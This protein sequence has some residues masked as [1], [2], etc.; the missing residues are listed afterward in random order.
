VADHQPEGGRGAGAALESRKG[1]QGWLPRHPARPQPGRSELPTA[2]TRG[3]APPTEHAVHSAVT[4]LGLPSVLRPPFS[5][6]RPPSL[7]PP[8]QSSCP[9]RFPV[10]CRS[11]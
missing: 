7:R 3:S 4:L 6:P 5:P 1:P 8:L 10:T 2:G 9:I 11:C